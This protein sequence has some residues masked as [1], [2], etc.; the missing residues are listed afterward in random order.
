LV[1]IA[2]TQGMGGH[3]L[4]PRC[5]RSRAA[6]E[7]VTGLGPVDAVGIRGK[8]RKGWT[9]STPVF[10][11]SRAALE[12]TNGR[13]LVDKDGTRRKRVD[14]I[15][16]R[17]VAMICVLEL[18]LA[19][20]SVEEAALA[21]ALKSDA[22]VGTC[23]GPEVGSSPTAGRGLADEFGSRNGAPSPP[24]DARPTR[25][26]GRGRNGARGRH[27]SWNWPLQ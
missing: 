7:V 9:K 14:K 13:G 17:G 23:R 15:D 26:T 6:L 2:N 8:A 20:T 3:C 5:G 12:I 1:V 18:V 22:G 19:S 21:V 25:F 24:G 11:Q 16:T 27:W 10:Y 4:R